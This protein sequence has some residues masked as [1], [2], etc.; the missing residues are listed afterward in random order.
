MG[1]PRGGGHKELVDARMMDARLA[2]VIA[3]R[4]ANAR[5]N[6]IP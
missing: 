5:C 3:R 1:Q 4:R 6:D 2:H